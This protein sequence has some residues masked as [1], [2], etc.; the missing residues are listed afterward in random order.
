MVMRLSATSKWFWCLLITL[1]N[2]RSQI[3]SVTS[4]TKLHICCKHRFGCVQH[5]EGLFVSLDDLDNISFLLD[6]DNDL[7]EENTHLF[8]E[9]TIFIFKFEKKQPIRL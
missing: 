1:N 6:K 9:V 2:L 4:Q 5:E 7:E 3:K 8:N